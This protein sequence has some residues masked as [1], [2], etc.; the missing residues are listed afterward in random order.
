MKVIATRR[1][2]ELI[3]RRGGRVWVWL[4][5]HA[6]VGGGYVWL[7][8]DCDPPATSRRMRYRT[9]KR[10]AHRFTQL[11]AEGFEL[12]VDFGRLAPP[13]ELH[14]DVKGPLGRRLGAYW[15]GGVF[16]GTDLEP[17]ES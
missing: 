12:N 9:Q 4:D 15:N 5:P 13:E 6:W 8:S 17:D 1:A 14:L 10:I 16:V 11:E 2:Q 3:R 7:E